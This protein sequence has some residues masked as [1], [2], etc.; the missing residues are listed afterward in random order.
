MAIKNPPKTWGRLK[1]SFLR[2]MK[3]EDLSKKLVLSCDEKMC[4]ISDGVHRE[5]RRV[6]EF[7]DSIDVLIGL[8]KRVENKY[9]KMRDENTLVEKGDP[10]GF[11]NAFRARLHTRRPRPYIVERVLEKAREL[12]KNIS[13]EDA[14]G[15]ALAIETGGI[16]V[17]G[18]KKQAQVANSFGVKVL[19]TFGKK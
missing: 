2:R 7:N 6:A 1:A 17:T 19:Y 5:V 16:L 8:A 12:G 18:D 11:A 4:L 14:E 10:R 15:I 9:V 13:R 3:S